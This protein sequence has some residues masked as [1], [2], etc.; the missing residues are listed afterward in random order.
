MIEQAH[1]NRECPKEADP[2]ADATINAILS[3][4]PDGKAEWVNEGFKEI[5]E[6]PFEVYLSRFEHDIFSPGSK[7][8]QMALDKFGKGE[9]G[10]TFEHQIETP[11]GISKWIQTTLTPLYT[12]EG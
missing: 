3:I 8:F 5:Y 10:L 9:K 1:T 4:Y 11:S 6:Y 7:G 12:E 2:E